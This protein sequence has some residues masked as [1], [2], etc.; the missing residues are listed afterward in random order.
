MSTSINKLVIRM[1][2]SESIARLVEFGQGQGYV[3][4]DDILKIIP[5]AESDSD[6]LENA[7]AALISAGIQYIEN[8]QN[9]ESYSQKADQAEE[10]DE[11][12][13]DDS[14]LR[15]NIHYSSGRCN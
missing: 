6:R 13:D 15:K 2:Q 4:Y 8:D 11:K 10:L 14:T 3:T 7:F 1:D 5:A 12:V 9:R